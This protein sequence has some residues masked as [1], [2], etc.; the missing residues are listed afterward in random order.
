LHRRW[1]CTDDGD[2]LIV[3]SSLGRVGSKWGK[4]TIHRRSS[5]LLLVA[6]VI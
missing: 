6:F 5:M 3:L 1:F 4:R 2:V